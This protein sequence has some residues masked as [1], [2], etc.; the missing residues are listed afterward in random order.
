MLRISLILTVLALALVAAPSAAAR[1]IAGDAGRVG[2]AVGA[3][4]SP[5]ACSDKKY[6]F[7]GPGASWQSAL[8]WR[9]RI[10]STPT[11]LNRQAVLNVLKQSFRNIVDSRNDCGMAD[12]VGATQTY[13]GTTSR[14]P[15][16]SADG[17]CTGQDG[18][19]VVGFGRLNGG[20]S[21]YTC[22]WWVGDEIVEAD[23]RLDKL[24]PWALTE[25]SCNGELM[26]EGLMTHEV[27]HAYGLG[28]VGEANHGRLTMSTFIDRLCDN[29]EAVL[30]RGD[31]L[32]LRA[33]Y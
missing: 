10:S 9:F 14:K 23:I 31:V 28:H 26:L 32:G 11:G 29:Q 16:V 1:P 7:L 6:K 5:S 20:F 27:G 4:G 25:K 3:G 30:G 8:D 15:G 13:L 19:N 2:T 18:H 21:G 24:T 33:L 12:Q 22:I 17:A